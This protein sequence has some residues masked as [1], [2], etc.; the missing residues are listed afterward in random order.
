M[1]VSESLPGR[2]VRAGHDP[3]KRALD[4]IVLAL[5]LPL[6]L[7]LLAVVWA[8]LV[9][10]G[11][12]PFYAQTRIGKDGTPF[13]L[14]KF[15]SMI[16]DADAALARLCAAD[17]A[18]AI[19]WAHNQKLRHDPRV[20]RLGR[21]L[22][23]TSLD[24]LPQLWNVARGEMSLVGPRPFMAEQEAL[25]RAAGGIGYFRLRPGLTG[26][27]Q[28]SDRGRT[29]FATRV[30]FDETYARTRSLL[31]DLRLIAATARAMTEGR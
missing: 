10:G 8:A 17:T 24:E 21:L 13:R 19:E 9:L 6:I 23:R 7:P 25:Y 28:V 31:L 15:R 16:P 20:T 22:R 5:L 1:P 3:A 4:L 29:D 2:F 30:G 26:L 18:L 11:G 14:W 27:W 12:Q